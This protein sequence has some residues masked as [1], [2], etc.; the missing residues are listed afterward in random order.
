MQRVQIPPPHSGQ[1]ECRR[2]RYNCDPDFGE[3]VGLSTN[4][5]DV[6]AVA[7]DIGGVFR[8]PAS[9]VEPEVGGENALQPPYS[10][11]VLP[12]RRLYVRGK[13]SKSHNE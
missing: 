2:L 5:D 10:A 12:E 13:M 8:R 11:R 7:G 1:C 6:A 3:T 4:A 9:Y